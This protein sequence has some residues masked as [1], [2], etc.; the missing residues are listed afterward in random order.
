M[1]M[2]LFLVRFV[3]VLRRLRCRV[4]LKISPHHLKLPTQK[5]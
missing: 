3:E 1:I 4:S 5:H 2:F